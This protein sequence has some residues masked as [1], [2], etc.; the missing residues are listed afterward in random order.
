M[1]KRSAY[2]WELPVRIYHWLNVALIPILMLT[3]L[4]IGKPPF[5][6]SGEAYS[7][8]LMGKMRIWHAWA[9]W[10]FIANFIVRFYWAFVGN[11]YAWFFPWGKG[12]LDDLWET[13]KYYLFLKKEHTIHVG[14][15]ALAMMSYFLF[16]WIGSVLIILT[17]LALQAEIHPGNLQDRLAGWLIPLLGQSF[18]VRS[19]HHLIAWFFVVFSIIHIYMA[20]RQ[21][22]LDDD[23]TVSSMING[24][25]FLLAEGEE[26]E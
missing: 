4:Y 14:H 1:Y 23:G 12:F 24:H 2:I 17:G 22:L 13:V 3:G 19:Y 15:N 25:K 26:H 20:V 8:F 10:I 5:T 6:L 7:I 11:K 9:A 16:M 21:D 18:A